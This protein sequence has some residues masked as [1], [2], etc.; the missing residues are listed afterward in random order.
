MIELQLK[1]IICICI[2]WFLFILRDSGFSQNSF[3]FE[4]P[5]AENHLYRLYTWLK[6][7]SIKFHTF[8]GICANAVDTFFLFIEITQKPYYALYYSYKWEIANIDVDDPIH[9][10]PRPPASYNSALRHPHPCR[11]VPEEFLKQTLLLKNSAEDIRMINCTACKE[12][13]S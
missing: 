7:I 9:C 6:E 13:T 5:P 8:L 4:I 3:R 11:I 2:D 1:L 12:L 10:F